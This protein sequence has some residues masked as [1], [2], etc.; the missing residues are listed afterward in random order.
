MLDNEMFKQAGAAPAMGSGERQSASRAILARVASPDAALVRSSSQSLEKE[1]NEDVAPLVNALNELRVTLADASSTTAVRGTSTRAELAVKGRTPKLT[2]H[3]MLDGSASMSMSLHEWATGNVEG[4][5][6]EDEVVALLG[7]VAKQMSTGQYG[8]F[9]S[10]FSMFSADR[11]PNGV[12]LD[13]ENGTIPGRAERG[14]NGTVAK[15]L[16]PKEIIYSEKAG[17][18]DGI[19]AAL[20]DGAYR[21][22]TTE[23]IPNLKLLEKELDADKAW[24]ERVKNHEEALVVLIVTDGAVHDSDAALSYVQ[25]LADRGVYI[26]TAVVGR[27]TGSVQRATGDHTF[28]VSEP[29]DLVTGVENQVKLAQSERG[30]RRYSSRV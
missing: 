4:V 26:M 16:K 10:E 27:S 22:G 29:K 15:V 5:K 6:A 24:A 14:G 28:T 18:L 19:F 23:I 12:D 17:D 2:L 21:G 11:Y 7:G 1:V 13:N 30:G 9:D 8:A 3:A 25:K 20:R